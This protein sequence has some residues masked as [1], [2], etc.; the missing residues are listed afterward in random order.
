MAALI[1]IPAFF[2]LRSVRIPAELKVALE[3]TPYGYTWSLLLFLVP[4]AVLALWLWRRRDLAVQR[5]AA[6][7]V[8]PLLVLQGFALDFFFGHRFFLFPKLEATTLGWPIPVIGGTIP[9]EELVFYAGGFTVV[10]LTYLW[11]DEVWL[12]RYNEENY[13]A[14]VRKAGR[15]LRFH[16]ASFVVGLA[17]ILAAAAYKRFV[18]LQPGW[19]EYLTFLIL[20]A[21]IPSVGFFAAVKPYINWRAVSL[22]FFMMLLVSLLWEATLAIPYG[23][24]GYRSEPMLGVRVGAWGNLPIEAVLVWAAATYATVIAYEVVKIWQAS[25]ERARAAFLANARAKP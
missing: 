22:T 9:V 21:F 3:A 17:L 6:V 4:L 1:A 16:R 24:W 11:C 2:A 25:G 7:R 12:A 15:L 10:L 8:L 20:V 18:L 5:R 13:R 23:W 14:A 19:P